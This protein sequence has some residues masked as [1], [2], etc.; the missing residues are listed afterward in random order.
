MPLKLTSPLGLLFVAVQDMV[1]V[2]VFPVMV[3][4][5]VKVL[6]PPLMGI[7]VTRTNDLATP[8]SC[9]VEPESPLQRNQNRRYSD[10]QDSILDK[11]C[12]HAER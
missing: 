10:G 7:P 5:M 9:F 11:R 8:G 6:I 2:M 12:S 4:F 3:A 1:P